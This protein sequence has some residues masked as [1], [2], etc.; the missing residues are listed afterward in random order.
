MLLVFRPVNGAWGK[1][2]LHTKLLPCE[3]EIKCF[4]FFQIEIAYSHTASGQLKVEDKPVLAQHAGN[5]DA[6]GTDVQS[7]VASATGDDDEDDIDIDDI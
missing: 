4:Q 2:I 3:T 5:G 1:I 6:A 7:S